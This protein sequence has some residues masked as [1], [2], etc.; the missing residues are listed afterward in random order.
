MS[1][2]RTFLASLRL[3]KDGDLRLRNLFGIARTYSENGGGSMEI[4]RKFG[5]ILC[6]TAL[7]TIGTTSGG[8]PTRS[9]EN[10]EWRRECEPGRLYDPSKVTKI[11]GK[12]LRLEKAVSAS[13][14]GHSLRLIVETHGKELPVVL[15]PLNFVR[16]LE[17]AIEVGD[18]VS[19]QGSPI[20]VEGEQILI[21]AR[22]TIHGETIDL[23]DSSGH[24]FWSGWKQQGTD[25]SV[26]CWV[27]GVI[28]DSSGAVIPDAVVVLEPGNLT[29]TT[30]PDGKYCFTR[31]DPDANTLTVVAQGFEEKRIELRLTA[32]PAQRIPL[33]GDSQRKHHGHCRHPNR[34]EVGRSSCPDGSNPAGDYQ[35]LWRRYSSRRGGVQF[36]NSRRKQLPEL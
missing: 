18:E 32:D 3:A 22:L 28:T 20:E 33:S 6:L 5:L 26:A 13:R 9:G 10:R 14:Q 23:R 2:P 16:S 8:N 17:P 7:A 31:V 1:C 35:A 30:G 27:Q 25:D 11:E 15:G 21:A 12:V 29:A 36:G 34:Q 24:P 19:V 4:T